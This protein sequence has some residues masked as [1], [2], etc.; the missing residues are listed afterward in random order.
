MIPFQSRPLATENVDARV[1]SGIHSRSADLAGV[2]LSR[3]VAAYVLDR[4]A[5]LLA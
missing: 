3:N 5:D 1:W 2:E 4:A